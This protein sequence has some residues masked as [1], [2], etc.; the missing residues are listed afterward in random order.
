MSG[1]DL[2]VYVL[3]GHDTDG[4]PWYRCVAHDELAP[5]HEAPCAGSSE[6]AYSHGLVDEVQQR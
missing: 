6:P 4:T 2:C 5:S 3:D 1:P